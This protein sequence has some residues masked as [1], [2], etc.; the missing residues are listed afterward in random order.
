MHRSEHDAPFPMTTRALPEWQPHPRCLGHG[1][2]PGRSSFGRTICISSET[3]FRTTNRTA[4]KTERKYGGAPSR[5]W[6][7]WASKSRKRDID[8]CG[9]TAAADGQG[10]GHLYIIGTGP[11][12]HCQ[13]QQPRDIYLNSHSATSHPWGGKG[14]ALL[15]VWPLIF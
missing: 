7:F 9:T 4:S 14:H 10:Q 5:G 15:H 2:N 11:A 13:A 8:R 6:D 3:C 12:S 1:G